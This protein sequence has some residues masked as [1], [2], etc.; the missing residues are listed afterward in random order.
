MGRHKPFTSTRV[1]IFAE[2]QRLLERIY[3]YPQCPWQQQPL[4]TFLAAVYR[5]LWT[6]AQSWVCYCKGTCKILP[7]VVRL[8][9]GLPTTQYMSSKVV[10]AASLLNDASMNAWRR[11]VFSGLARRAWKSLQEGNWSFD[12]INTLRMDWFLWCCCRSLS[13][14]EKSSSCTYACSGKSYRQFITN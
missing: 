7:S 4:N 11:T 6:E 10:I 2:P 9:A 8:Y 14:M 1:L 12:F 3:R 13:L 5:R